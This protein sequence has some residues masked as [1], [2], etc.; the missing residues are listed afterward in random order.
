MYSFQLAYPIIDALDN[1][2]RLV[3]DEIDSKMQPKLTSKIIELFN[4]KATNPNRAQ[5][6]F[7]IHDTNILSAK[8]LRRDQV[9][10]TQKDAYGATKLYSLADYKVR[11]NASFEKEYLEGKYGGTPII[12]DFS[13]LFV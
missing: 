1:G 5:L 10:F 4:S 2:K 7:T 12:G 11:N 9:W 8:I 13:K 6:I 3:I